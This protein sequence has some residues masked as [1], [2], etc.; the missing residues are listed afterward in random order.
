MAKLEWILFAIGL[1]L[2]AVWGTQRF[3]SIVFSRAAI[4]KFDANKA[5]EPSN[6]IPALHGLVSRSEAGFAS[7]SI[8]RVKAYKD[9]LL[10]KVD[11]PLAVLRIP[12]IHLEVPVFNGTDDLTLNRGIGRIVGTA[13]VGAGGNLGIAGHRDG[14]F[15]SLKDVERGDVIE[16]ARPGQTDFY[17]I[18]GIQIAK[19][20]DVAF[21]KPT[22]APSLTLVTCFHFHIVGSAPKRYIVRASIWS[23][24]PSKEGANKDSASMG[25][26][27][28]NKENEK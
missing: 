16:L 12:K 9:S 25:N 28:N 3:D 8:K 15:R 24:T 27:S 4:A 6:S 22:P 23:F 26:R 13:Q 18:D 10:E 2:L 1:A 5:T 17:V 20:E 21:L 19:P 14:F 11:A 7:W